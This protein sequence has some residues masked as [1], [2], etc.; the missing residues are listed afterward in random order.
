MGFV[1]VGLLVTMLILL[2]G[3]SNMQISIVHADENIINEIK[4]VYRPF[5]TDD[6]FKQC[7][8]EMEKIELGLK[9]KIKDL[10]GAHNIINA[11]NLYIFSNLGF[12]YQTSLDSIEFVALP[13]I[14]K[15]KTGNC[16]GLST[17]YVYLGEKFDIPFYM[18]LAPNHCFVR[19]DDGIEKINIEMSDKGASYNNQE[20]VDLC[21]L[22][23]SVIDNTAYLKTLNKKQMLGA[24]YSNLGMIY[25]KQKNYSNAI[26]TLKKSLNFI[27]NLPETHSN[28]GIAFI[29]SGYI[30]EAIKELNEA[31]KLN[32]FNARTYSNLGSAYDDKREYDLAISSYKKALQIEPD[33]EA[34]MNNL[35]IAVKHKQARTLGEK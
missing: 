20:C 30:D 32:P 13:S 21:K 5:Y 22:P 9:D 35:D 28:L 2:Y 7:N 25:L 17:L 23:S 15:Q 1:K 31:I 27:S 3:I 26:G 33:S 19:Y 11:I 16:I 6:D 10:K 8:A 29:N 24:L 4:E 18:V 34:I 14:V 12:K